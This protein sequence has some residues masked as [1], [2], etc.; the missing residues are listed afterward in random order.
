[1]I[2]RGCDRAGDAALHVD[3]AAAVERVVNDLG[4]ERRSRPCRLVAGRHHVGVAGED[5]MR[6]A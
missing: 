5:E 6:R 4:C 1:M 3:R 2:E